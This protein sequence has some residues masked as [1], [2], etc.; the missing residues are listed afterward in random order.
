MMPEENESRKP[1]IVEERKASWEAQQRH[2]LA[3]HHSSFIADFLERKRKDYGDTNKFAD[4]EEKLTAEGEKLWKEYDAL[5]TKMIELQEQT[6]R[7]LL[8]WKTVE[9]VYRD[10]LKIDTYIHQDIDAEKTL[11]SWKDNFDRA[12]ALVKD[13]AKYAEYLAAGGEVGDFRRRILSPD[14]KVRAEAFQYFLADSA[15]KSFYL[16]ETVKLMFDELMEL[17]KKIRR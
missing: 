1:F 16:I 12:Q 9:N 15:E 3:A 5:E 10:W 14:P 2:R 7:D 11:Q 8:D 17:K 4:D 13:R 6:E